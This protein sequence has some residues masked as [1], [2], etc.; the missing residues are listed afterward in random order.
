[1]GQLL[2][3]SD[4]DGG[5]P[6]LDVELLEQAGDGLAGV[7]VEVAG[8]FVGEQELG[9]PTRAR[10]SATRCC[11]PP[12]N[13]PGRCAALSASPTSVRISTAAALASPAGSAPQQQGH[14]HVLQLP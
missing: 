7:R 11:S 6:A 1:M 10:A 13:S 5:Q 9:P 12:D 2:V 3:V 14:H 8:G 4:E